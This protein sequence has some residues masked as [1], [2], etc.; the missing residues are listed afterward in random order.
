ML[1]LRDSQTNESRQEGGP[2]RRGPGR[3]MR[4]AVM[5]EMGGNFRDA[6]PP[7]PPPTPPTRGTDGQPRRIPERYLFLLAANNYCYLKREQNMGVPIPV[8]HSKDE[9]RLFIPVF[10]AY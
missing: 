8:H 10:I 1:L 3:G 4:V 6:P 7:P 5:R 2:R 9:R